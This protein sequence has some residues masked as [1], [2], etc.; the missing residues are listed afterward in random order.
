MI[1]NGRDASSSGAN[2]KALPK[3]SGEGLADEHMRQVWIAK[4]ANVYTQHK[5]RE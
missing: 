4:V 5:R 3:R 2:S 1:F